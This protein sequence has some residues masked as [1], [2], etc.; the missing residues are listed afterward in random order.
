MEQ[1]RTAFYFIMVLSVLVLVHEWGHFI[2][3]KL[4]GMHVEDFSLFFG[5]RL[6]R[7]G[8]RNGTEYNIRA[9]PMGGFVK[10][11]G[12]E[13]DDISNGAPIFPKGSAVQRNYRKTMVGLTEEA[14]SAI[15]FESVSPR[16]LEA[17]EQSIGENAQLT[18]N[19]RRELQ[20]L[21][22]STGL[23]TGEHK[24]IEAILNAQAQP[25]D[26]NGYNQKPLWQRA[27]TIFRRPVHES[28][29]RLCFVLRHGLYDRPAR[30]ENRKCHRSNG[31]RQ[32]RRARR[33]Q[34]FRSHCA[35]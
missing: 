33:P 10:I 30:S 16:I 32:T 2:V 12:M 20:S 14:L 13:P 31:E 8:V 19:G 4:C 3:A 18:E 35:D 27:A 25:P 11:A 17:V 24:Y 26:P 21:L 6:I 22:A 9:I 28:G 1:I 5:K 34:T 29:I 7:L 23:N 15:D